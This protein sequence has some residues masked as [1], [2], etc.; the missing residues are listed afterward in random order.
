M[1]RIRRWWRILVWGYWLKPKEA[2]DL[3]ALVNSFEVG[4]LPAGTVE[5]TLSIQAKFQ[6]VDVLEGAGYKQEE[7]WRCVDTWSY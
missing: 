1:H 6:A 2:R 7:A 4:E 5:S 3:V